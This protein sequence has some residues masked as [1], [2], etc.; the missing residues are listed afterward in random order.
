MD[1]VDETIRKYGTGVP[2]NDFKTLTKKLEAKYNDYGYFIGW[3][4]DNDFAAMQKESLQK[5]QKYAAKYYQRYV[6]WQMRNGFSNIYKNLR[7]EPVSVPH[8]PALPA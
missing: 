7:W 8:T 1:T 5:L 4:K 3:E 6:P 2:P